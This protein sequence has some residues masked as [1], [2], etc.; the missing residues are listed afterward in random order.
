[1]KK[2]EFSL[3]L[4]KGQGYSYDQVTLYLHIIEP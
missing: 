2:G 3:S 4:V 1:M